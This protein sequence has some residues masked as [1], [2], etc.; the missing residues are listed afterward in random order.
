M[1]KLH[2]Q[3]SNKIYL[4]QFAK[5]DTILNLERLSLNDKHSRPHQ[6]GINSNEILEL[7][8]YLGTTVLTTYGTFFVFVYNF[9]LQ[10]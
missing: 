4:Q 6:G 7:H 8:L 5:G 3:Y 2:K 10:L 1:H 9:M